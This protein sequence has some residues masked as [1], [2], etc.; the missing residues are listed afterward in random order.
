LNDKQVTVEVL[1]E[2]KRNSPEFKALNLTGKWPLLV[3]PE[4]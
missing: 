4:G 1:D 2:A 3:T